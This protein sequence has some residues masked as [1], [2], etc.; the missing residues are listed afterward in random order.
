MARRRKTMILER[1]DA[2]GGIAVLADGTRV[3]W[4]AELD[5]N[6][7][8]RSPSGGVEVVPADDPHPIAEAFRELRGHGASVTR[9]LKSAEADELGRV[10]R[11]A[12]ASSPKTR[13]GAPDDEPTGDGSEAGKDVINRVFPLPDGLREAVRIARDRTGATNRSFVA[14]AVT[15]ELP[16]LVS[17]LTA[18]G[19]G[20][21]AGPVRQVRL[22]LSRQAGTLD[23]LRAASDRTG[24]PASQLLALCLAAAARPPAS[25][26]GRRGRTPRATVG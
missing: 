10:V 5:P 15:G 8:A 2:T 19:F 1:S 22:P 11:G 21:A 4:S 16:G 12:G 24:V 25:K 3:Y 13:S 6:L 17:H 7:V 18:L 14:G 26:K 9:P 20:A 23:A